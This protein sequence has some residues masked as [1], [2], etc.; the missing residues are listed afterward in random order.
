MPIKDRPAPGLNVEAVGVDPLTDCALSPDAMASRAAASA[1]TTIG[2]R[3]SQGSQA[4][5]AIF[6]GASDPVSEKTAS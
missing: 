3:G 4:K 5:W 1:R 6:M 2:T